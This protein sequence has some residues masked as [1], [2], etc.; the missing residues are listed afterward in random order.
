M[1]LLSIIVP[2]YNTEDRLEACLESLLAQEVR[3]FELILVDD[4]SSD[5]SSEICRKYRELHPGVVVFL[6]GPNR[7]VS[8]ARNRGLGVARGEW[9][10]F[11]DSDDRVQPELYRYLHDRA[12]AADAELSCCGIRRIAPE[13]ERIITDL[14]CN[15][16]EVIGSR[17]EIFRRLFIPLLWARPECNG[18]LL[19]CLFRR[20]LIEEAQI[21]FV[22]GLSME[23]D[24][25]FLLQYLLKVRRMA[26]SDRPL[27]DYLHHSASLSAV[28]FLGRSDQ[29]RESNW[30][31][32]S[33]RQYEIFL[34]SGLAERRPEWRSEFWLRVYYHE[35]QLVCCDRSLDKKERRTRLRDISVRARR[36]C[37]DLPRSRMGRLFCFILFHC[38][39]GMPLF[40][41]LKRMK[42]ELEQKYSPWS[43]ARVTRRIKKKP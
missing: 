13:G 20:D 43:Q 41:S 30:L 37:P 26:V 36:E 16:E 34:A 32:R 14:P 33:R 17:E 39:G 35:V 9:I 21:R 11:C 3:D 19:C 15:G 40:C 27:Y 24:E 2:V 18:F 6:S 31:L 7:G 12:V 25:L 1:P 29:F 22:E 5:G 8:A 10:A 38:P 42:N 23:E 28:H 4:G